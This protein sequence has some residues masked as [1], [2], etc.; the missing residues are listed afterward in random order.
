MTISHL[1][2]VLKVYDETCRPL[3][4]A[5]QRA[6][7]ENGHIYQLHRLGWEDVTPA[8]SAAGGFTPA[9]LAVI[10]DALDNAFEWSFKSSISGDRQR[11]LEAVA[12]L[13]SSE[14]S[15]KYKRGGRVPVP[16]MKSHL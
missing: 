1:P 2:A 14:N 16:G 12:E 11:V 3:G 4:Q 7:D 6:S 9:R 15:S 8:E 5:V 10:A 13:C